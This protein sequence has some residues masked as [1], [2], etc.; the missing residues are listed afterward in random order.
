MKD[1]RRSTGGQFLAHST[2]GLGVVWGERIAAVMGR[3]GFR[4][5][6]FHHG[7]KHASGVNCEPQIRGGLKGRGEYR[8][9]GSRSGGE[10]SGR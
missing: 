8:T 9:V 2:R 4:T 7:V 3:G 10:G 5:G 6:R 1:S